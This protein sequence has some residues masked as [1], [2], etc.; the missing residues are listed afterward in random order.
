MSAR[1]GTS[2]DVTFTVRRG[3]ARATVTGH[4]VGR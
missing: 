3:K 1:P 2:G 4:F